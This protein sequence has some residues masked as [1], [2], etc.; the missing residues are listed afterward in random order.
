MEKQSLYD[1]T[2]ELM[3]EQ[4]WEQVIS[5][6]DHK[7]LKNKKNWRLYWNAAWSN[8]KLKLF[9]EAEKYFQSAVHLTPNPKDKSICLTFLGITKLETKDL[10]KAHEHL[11][12]ALDIKDSSLT[13]KGLALALMYLDRVDE[14]EQ[15][16]KDGIDLE[17]NNKERLAA[18]GDFLLDVGRLDDAKT[19]QSKIDGLK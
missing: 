2:S 19:I 9:N 16:H 14:A 11:K 8:Y 15:V 12:Q 7:V 4:K 3:R 13:R 5:E 18:Y 17:P 1:R 10:E 6:L